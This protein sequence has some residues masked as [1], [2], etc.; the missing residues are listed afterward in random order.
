MYRISVIIPTCDRPEMLERALDCVEQQTLKE[1]EVVVV[2]NGLTPLPEG[3]HR[4]FQSVSFLNIPPRAGAAIARNWGA[5]KAKGEILAFLDDDDKWPPEFLEK[6]Y[7]CLV[8]SEADLV[9]SPLHIIKE[10]EEEVMHP[11][12]PDSSGCLPRWYGIGYGGSNTMVKRSSFWAVG[13]YKNWLVT[14]EDRALIIELT[15]KEMKIVCCN[16]TFAVAH[17]HSG[18]QLTDNKTLLLGKLCFLTAYGYEMPKRELAED[19]F[20]FLIYLSR[21]WKF[22]LWIFA[23][24][25]APSAGWRRFKKYLP[26][27]KKELKQ[28]D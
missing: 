8:E 11:V 20:A 13:G 7:N 3:F 27:I 6:M 4:R 12:L 17:K 25:V 21:E 2:D 22:P 15:R 28:K 18:A 5:M 1:K 19:R 16:A 24:F 9:C 10:K 26:F 14:G 23:F